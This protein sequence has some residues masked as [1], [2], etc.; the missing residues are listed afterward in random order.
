MTEIE[1]GGDRHTGN[2]GTIM[3]EPKRVEAIRTKIAEVQSKMT[4]LA[5]LVKELDDLGC[6]G[7]F[8]YTPGEDGYGGDL[9]FGHV[10]HD[11]QAM[12]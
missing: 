6:S 10:I 11:K 12:N 2:N 1:Q 7:Y 9:E 5:E 8:K 4:R 3:N